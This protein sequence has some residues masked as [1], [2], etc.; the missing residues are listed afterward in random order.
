MLKLLLY[1]MLDF[2][3]V[4]LVVLEHI[5]KVREPDNVIPNTLVN[6]NLEHCKSKGYHFTLE[7]G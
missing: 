7:N 6:H 3:P 2:K 5:Y 1:K 4:K